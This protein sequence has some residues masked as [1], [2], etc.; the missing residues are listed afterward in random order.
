MASATGKST[1][2]TIGHSSH[3]FV[4]FVRLLKRHFTD[5][6]VDVRS[7]PYSRRYSQFNRNKL[8]MAL[9][10]QGIDYLF[11]GAELGARSQDPSCYKEGRVQYRKLAGT[12]RFHSGIQ[13]VLDESCR[14][15]VALMCAEKDPLNCHRTILVARELVDRG[16]DVQHILA[17]GKLESH[18]AAL[19]RL[20][21]QLNLLEQDLFESAESMRDRAYAIQESRIAYSVHDHT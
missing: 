1:V 13:R 14:M 15:R 12:S 19:R 21:T 11:M 7:V 6:V 17:S 16:I 18:E 8:E 2:F 3:E 4:R 20:I 9:K 5:A 10:S